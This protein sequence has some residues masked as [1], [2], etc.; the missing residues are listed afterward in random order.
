MGRERSLIDASHA[1]GEE[2]K[3]A[4]R[5]A[6]KAMEQIPALFDEYDAFIV[7]H[8]PDSSVHAHRKPGFIEKNAPKTKEELFE[9]LATFDPNEA[10]RGAFTDAYIDVVVRPGT[11]K[12]TKISIKVGGLIDPEHEIGVEGLDYQFVIQKFGEYGNTSRVQS[13][14]R[15]IFRHFRVGSGTSYG[16]AWMRP[17]MPADINALKGLLKDIKRNDSEISYREEASL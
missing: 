14:D 13:V 17:I 9:R 8:L 12:A 2:S 4:R 6:E 1:A 10:L 7:D 5:E 15:T 16:P 3:R 11:K